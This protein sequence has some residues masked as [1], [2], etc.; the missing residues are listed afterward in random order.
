MD[1]EIPEGKERGKSVSLR[2]SSA[3][4]AVLGASLLSSDGAV[5]DSDSRSRRRT[6]SC[7]GLLTAGPMPF[8]FGHAYSA[9]HPTTKNKTRTAS[10]AIERQNV[11]ETT[12]P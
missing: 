11:I 9:N 12:L 3:A 10:T 6:I 5:G 2:D 8:T 1:I 4:A 7:G